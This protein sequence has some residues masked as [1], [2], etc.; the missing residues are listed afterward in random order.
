MNKF[1]LAMGV[2]VLAI[3]APAVAGD[4]FYMGLG[5]SYNTNDNK[6]S[7]NTVG[8]WLLA[9][10]RTA[11]NTA[12]ADDIS[13]EVFGGLIFGGYRAHVAPSIVMGV[14]VDAAVFDGET[15]DSHSQ[16]YP[17]S[18]GAFTIRHHFSQQWMSTIRAKLGF[19]VAPD[20]NVFV[21]GGVAFSDVE[22]NSTYSDTYT[23]PQNIP[24]QS[25]HAGGIE[26]GYVYGGGLDWHLGGSTNL[27]VEYLRADLGEITN[28]RALN[29][30]TGAASTEV[31]TS[32]A[33]IESESIR[34]GLSWDLNL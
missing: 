30:S 28:V 20:A 29:F 22:L 4:G 23:A 18:T 12:P 10:N 5:A 26:S 21:T 24:A 9:A 25:A 8:T 7:Q 16:N 31:I 19:D 6:A 3:A 2:S 11:V 34:V 15:I 1:A 17:A 33:Q 13:T 27:R 32:K 14:E